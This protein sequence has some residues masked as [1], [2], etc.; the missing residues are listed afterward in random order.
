LAVGRKSE[1]HETVKLGEIERLKDKGE[2]AVPKY[3]LS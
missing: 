1:C 2:R 3:F